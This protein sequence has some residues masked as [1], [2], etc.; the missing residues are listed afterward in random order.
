M[1]EQFVQ[2]HFNLKNL[3]EGQETRREVKENLPLLQR[4]ADFVIG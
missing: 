2:L 4:F 1:V 3:A